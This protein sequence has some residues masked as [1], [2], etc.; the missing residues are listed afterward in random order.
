MKAFLMH[1]G[2][3][4]DLGRELPANTAD[5]VQDLE[6]GTLFDAMAAGDQFLHAVARQAMLS[7]LTEPAEIIYRQRVLADCLAQPLVVRDIYGVAVEAIGREKRE[8]LSLFRATPASVLNRSVRVLAIFLAQ[9]RK[10]RTI[11]GEHAGDFGSAGFTRFFAMLAEE[12]DDGFFSTAEGHLRA[13]KFSHGVLIS[14]ALGTGNK[15]TGL[16]LREPREQRWIDRMPAGRRPGYSFQVPDRDSNGFQALSQ[17]T[18]QGTNLVANALAQSCDHIL[19]FFTMLCTELAFY[20]GCLNLHERLTSLGEPACCPVPVA[21][22]QTAL[23]A[24]GL[25]DA[26]LTLTAGRRVAG[27]DLAADGKRLI[28]ITGANQG[29]K[30]TFLRSVGVAQLMMQA[31]MFTPAHELRASLCRGVFSHYKREEDAT[32]TGGKLAEEL[33][34]MS[35]VV[36]Q[37]SAGSLLLCNESFASTHEREGAEIARQIIRAL[38]DRGVRILFVTHLFDLAHGCY[39][40]QSADALFLRAQRQADGTRSFRMVP[41]EPLPTSHGPDVYQRVFA[42][43]PDHAAAC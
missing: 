16:V 33:S 20:V 2:Q 41:G 22:G 29:G 34:R 18:D 37:L 12:L 42:V 43:S 30:S 6:L 27:N 28:M 19:S 5:L 17:L 3:D 38:L 1:P 24:R 23:S 35:T 11:A 21:D 39:L 32:M 7:S 26:C 9:L 25:Y 8:F 13:L 14:A 15:G 40:E 36:G 31:G 10:L 4:F